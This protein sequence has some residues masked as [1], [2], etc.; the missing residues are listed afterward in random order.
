VQLLTFPLPQP[1]ST[2]SASTEAL[3]R[4]SKRLRRFVTERE[5]RSREVVGAL[6]RLPAIP[7]ESPCPKEPKA[8]LKITKDA[9]RLSNDYARSPFIRQESKLS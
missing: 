7:K 9:K 6:R 8:L 4:G 2:A 1:H 5:L 3:T